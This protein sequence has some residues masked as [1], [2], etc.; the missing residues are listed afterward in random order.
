[1]LYL[2]KLISSNPGPINSNLTL[3]SVVFELFYRYISRKVIVHL[4]LTSV[5][6]ELSDCQYPAS[7]IL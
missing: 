6:F 4:T 7:E 1:M 3:T 2:N 5:V